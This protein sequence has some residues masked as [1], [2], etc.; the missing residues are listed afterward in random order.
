MIIQ[1]L[2]N[3]VMKLEQLICT[4]K[5]N[6]IHVILERKTNKTVY[7]QLIR[8]SKRNLIH[9]I[10]ERKTNCLFVACLELSKYKWALFSHLSFTRNGKIV[11]AMLRKLVGHSD[12]W[13]VC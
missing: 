12:A 10:M 6:L 8:T 1:L 3:S 2:A 9:V 4:S 7:L 5:R 11:M 13:V